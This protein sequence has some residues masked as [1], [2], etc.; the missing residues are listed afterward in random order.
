MIVRTRFLLL[1]LGGLTLAAFALTPFLVPAPPSAEPLASEGTGRAFEQDGFRVTME[2][3]SLRST[4]APLQAWDDLEL[5]FTVREARA[6]GRPLSGLAPLSWLVRRAEGEGLPDREQCR[7]EIRALLA[8]RLAKASAV[9]FNQYFLVTLDDNNSLS[10]VDPQLES[11]RTK[12]VG[13]VPLTSKGADFVL[14]PD[15][16]TVL[17]TLP[18]VAR[19]AAADIDRRMAR[20]LE[21]AGRPAE[22]ALQP[23]GAYAWVGQETGPGIDVIR[24]DT[25]ERAK[26]L[27][28]GPGPHEFAFR[29]DS[30]Q[31]YVLERGSGRLHAFDVHELAP[32]AVLDTGASALTLA[33]SDLSRRLYVPFYD[34]RV[35]VIDQE[36]F[37]RLADLELGPGLTAL[38]VDPSGRFGFALFEGADRLVLFDTATGRTTHT[39]ET[40][41]GPARVEFTAGFA[42]L[43]HSGSEKTILIDLSVLAQ[44]EKVVATSLPMGQLAPL[45]GLAAT[46]APLLAPLPEGGGAVLLHPADRNLYHFMEGMNAPM[47][48]YRTYPW[49]ARGVLLVDRTLREVEDGRYATSFQASEP[50]TYTVPFVLPTSPQLFGCFELEIGGLPKVPELWKSLRY[51]LAGATELTSGAPQVLELRLFDAASNAP[52]ADLADVAVLVRRGPRWQWNGVARPTG[53]GLYRC[54]PSF[55]EPGRYQLFLAS[56]TRG[57]EFGALPA[58]QLEVR[59]GAAT[60]LTAVAPDPNPRHE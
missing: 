8:G 15:R 52:L 23:D 50:G 10:I 13:I 49:S 5:A 9:D 20:Y 45:E 36:N 12:T 14:A 21:L 42:Y 24:V 33:A 51:E 7:R 56:G 27:E 22:I 18:E 39:V 3:S 38:E 60:D 34:G 29:A 54:E 53:D 35:A 19:L 40:E 30:R 48:A 46:L 16:R 1:A 58:V 37:A 11:A 6:G 32:E 47:G 25:F 4:D 26:H 59:V 41:R 31:A 44:E 55:P 2:A 57:V 43:S 28:L 17:V